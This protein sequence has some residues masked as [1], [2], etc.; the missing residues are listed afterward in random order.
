MQIFRFF[1]MPEFWYS[2]LRGTTPVLYATLAA[3]IASQ[4]GILNLAIEG[5]MLSAALAGV[6]VS[7]F[8]GAGTLGLTLGLLSGLLVGL[9]FAWALG[10]FAL[11]LRANMVISSIALNLTATGGTIFVMYTII[12]DKGVTS[13]LLSSTFPTV[14]L[15][16]LKYI[17]FAGDF[18]DRT[19]SG[20]N[21]L[22][23]VAILCV[24]LLW[25]LL[26]KTPLG[27]QIRAV[28]E[29]REAA[30]SVGIKIGHVQFI[31]LT[32]SGLMAAMGGLFLSMGYLSFFN[33][34]MTS[35]RGYLALAMNAMSGANPA[36]ALFATLIYGF[37]DA[38]SNNIA[39]V[40]Q[41]YDLLFKLSPYL[42]V[43]ILY[44]IYA[45]IVKKR[46]KEDFE[47]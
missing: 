36:T 37:S 46:N 35:G 44:S 27:L 18:I 26:Y 43:I 15:P 29:S 32:I 2:V 4:C 6:L 10:L 28:G 41:R 39:T 20:H 3:N 30:E 1:F 9:V 23:Y 7:A 22:T 42:F 17:P 40:N 8:A 14:K 16:L 45:L 25:L 12:R 47:F 38:V 11:K 13:S 24:V 19:F 31:S 34:G 21:I 5:A 33:A